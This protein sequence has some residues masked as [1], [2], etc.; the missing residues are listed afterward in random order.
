MLVG[1]IVR[2]TPVMMMVIRRAVVLP[3]RIMLV[4]RPVLH[5]LIRFRP[6]AM[7]RH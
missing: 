7:V 4:G 5:R 1:T 6:I 2:S 3:V